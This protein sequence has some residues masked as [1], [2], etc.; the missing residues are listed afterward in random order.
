MTKLI[1]ILLVVMNNIL[2]DVFSK[3]WLKMYDSHYFFILMYEEQTQFK[4]VLTFHFLCLKTA[5]I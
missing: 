4:A 1:S 3:S 2:V 5:H